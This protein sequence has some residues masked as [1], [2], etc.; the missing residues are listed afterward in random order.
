MLSQDFNLKNVIKTCFISIIFISVYILIC[1]LNIHSK[2]GW[3]AKN[4]YSFDNNESAKESIHSNPFYIGILVIILLTGLF[5][6]VIYLD[7]ILPVVTTE[8][9]SSSRYDK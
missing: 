3:K 6:V 8:E 4:T 5:G 9:V 7:S 1:R 2:M